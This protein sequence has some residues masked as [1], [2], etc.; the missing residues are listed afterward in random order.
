MRLMLPMSN[1]EKHALLHDAAVALQLGCLY[2]VREQSQPDGT[3]V[4]SAKLSDSFGFVDHPQLT[5]VQ[6]RGELVDFRCDCAD[7]R[8]AR[9]FCVHC[10]A[11][12]DRFF[13]EIC[14][15]S[16]TLQE[17]APVVPLFPEAPA[18]PPPVEQIS[19]T[20]CNSRQDM[21][22]GKLNPRIPLV[23]YQQMYGNNA[24]ARMLYARHPRW[25]GSCFGITA[26]A[27]MFFLPEDPVTAPDFRVGAV[28]PADLQLTS[29]SKQL[30]M[31]LHTFIEGMHILQS[32]ERISRPRN[33]QLRNPHCLDEL[34]Q[35]VLHFQ[36]TKTEPV[37]MGVWRTPRFDGGH[38]IFP[39]WLEPQADGQD[40]LY[41]YDPNH[42]RKIRYAYLGK[43]DTGHYISW[44]FP[45]NDFTEYSSAAGGQLS[46]DTYADYKQTWNERGGEQSDAMMS[47]P[48]SVAI[49]RTDGTVLFRV[50]QEG[51]ESF[52]DD[53]FQIPMTDL[54]DG[55]DEQVLLSLPAGNYLVRS[56]D[57]RRESLQVQLTHT[58]QSICVRT[59]APEIEILADDRAMTVSARIARAGCSYAIELDAV[60]EDES[61]TIVL[62]GTTAEGGLCFGCCSGTL[63]AEGTLT[64][65]LAS[66]YIDEELAD[67]EC[68]ERQ[69]IAIFHDDPVSQKKRSL[70]TNADQLESVPA[71]D[72]TD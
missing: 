63:R 33:R 57:P 65:E 29:R 26:T 50:T 13:E 16:C 20:F 17:E 70:I 67:L 2:S 15:R 60:Y 46:F 61:R 56:E 34:C 21:Y 11:L 37:A 41:I 24:R 12:A 44:R 51:T 7:F 66:L 40:R 54:D 25:G 9:R 45:M 3:L 14:T 71:A 4:V 58:Q 39:Y 68:I 8:K 27:S 42:P 6:P 22:P 59:S 48:R 43:N 10:A 36:Q 35:R 30:H 52:C 31:T 38:S 28:Y 32:H 53:M 49:L 23:R 55:A 1:S 64:G 69:K 18:S 72:V 5:T 62:E 19:Y 47:V